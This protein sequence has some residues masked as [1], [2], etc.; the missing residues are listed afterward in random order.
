MNHL[1]GMRD[2]LRRSGATSGSGLRGARPRP[3]NTFTRQP[4]VSAGAHLFLAVHDGVHAVGPL[5][6]RCCPGMGFAKVDDMRS[7]PP[8]TPAAMCPDSLHQRSAVTRL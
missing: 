1:Q 5:V 4:C 3:S 7:W 8:T 6:V 2:G